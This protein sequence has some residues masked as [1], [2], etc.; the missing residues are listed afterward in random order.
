MTKKV[1]SAEP[2]QVVSAPNAA[3][4]EWLQIATAGEIHDSLL[5]LIFAARMQIEVVAQQLD[6]AGLEFGNPLRGAVEH[7]QRA[8]EVGRQLIGDLDPPD[9]NDQLWEDFVRQAVVHLDGAAAVEIIV[10]GDFDALVSNQAQRLTARQ[11]A[12]EA[13]RNAVR[14]G[15]AS[16]VVVGSKSLVDR[17]VQL[18]ITDNG[19]GFDT[20]QSKRGYGMRLMH[21]RVQ[22]AGGELSIESRHSA[23]TTVVLVMRAYDEAVA[24]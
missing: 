7:L 20:Q 2:V 8:M 17:Q 10:D 3:P 18:T 5:P 6:D 9:P 21:S 13:V 1:G 22:F 15:R 23:G 16:T 24:D 19:L 12:L 4:S 11:I 14:H